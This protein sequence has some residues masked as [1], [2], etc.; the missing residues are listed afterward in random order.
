MAELPR[1]TG[2]AKCI[3]P[4]SN[5]GTTGRGLRMACTEIT[6]DATSGTVDLT[7]DFGSIGLTG[8]SG[9]L[10]YLAAPVPVMVQQD[11]GTVVAGTITAA[12]LVTSGTII[13][14]KSY[15]VYAFC[16]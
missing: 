15:W 12:G 14:G 11:T 5:I 2:L 6:A 3:S 1:K 7:T 4:P 9:V 10:T 16:I 8:A 13:S